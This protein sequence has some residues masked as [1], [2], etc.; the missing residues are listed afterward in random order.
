MADAQYTKY[1]VAFL[2]ILGF[3]KL[4]NNPEISCE[5]IINIYDYALYKH[6]TFFKDTAGDV[7]S[8]IKMKIMSD[9]ICLY[10]K[11]DFPDALLYLAGYCTVFQHDL[12]LVKNLLVRGGITSGE[13]Y[14]KDD[15]IF[16]PALT[17][18]YLLEEHNAKFPR[19]IIRKETIDEGT[20]GMTKD[21]L[22]LIWK[23]LL[24]D[25]DAFYI[26]NYFQLYFLV[27][28]N[29]AQSYAKA[30]ET[31]KAVKAIVADYLDTTVDESIRQKYLY[32]EK[33][34]NRYIFKE[35]PDA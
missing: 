15:I 8:N 4:V 18:A 2:D 31:V 24:R 17:E 28:P 19:I 10:I 11:T 5:E 27:Y 23:F 26:L 25:D 7:R 29:T 12:L 13:M 1:Y 9:S 3:K 32:I 34:I 35:N 21:S 6:E 20:S 16:G 22:N 30:E 14:A 33:K